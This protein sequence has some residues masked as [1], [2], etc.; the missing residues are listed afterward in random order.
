[1]AEVFP[2][3]SVGPIMTNPTIAYDPSIRS[4]SEDGLIIS[5][6]KFTGN[7]KKFELSYINLT[8]ADKALLIALQDA[9]G[10]GAETITWTNEDPND[11]T[12]YT[13]RL[14]Q[15]GIKFE[16]KLSD[17]DLYTA[18]FTFIEA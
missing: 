6:R 7:K 15:D 13:V 17:Y 5:R 8:A 18:R 10:V 1:M 16:N 4:Q 3:L 2:S 14:S 11:V 12:E 9:V